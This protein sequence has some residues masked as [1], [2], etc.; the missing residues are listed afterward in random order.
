MPRINIRD[1]GR[2]STKLYCASALQIPKADQ[3]PTLLVPE[4]EAPASQTLAQGYP[5]RDAMQ[6]WRTVNTGLQAIIRNP[7]TQMMHVM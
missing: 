5:P 3:H 2:S 4:R 6:V 7:T 1:S